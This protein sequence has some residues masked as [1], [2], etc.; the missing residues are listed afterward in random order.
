M[1]STPNAPGGLF[2]SIELEPEDTCLYRRIFLHWTYGAG[3]IYTTEDIERAKRSHSFSREYD[4]HYGGQ[5]GN[6]FHTRDIDL[7]IEKGN[8]YP[9]PTIDNNTIHSQTNKSMGID[10]SFGSSQFAIVILEQIDGVIN[11][12]FSE[13]YKHPDY[14]SRLYTVN[15]L[16]NKFAPNKIY[17][18]GTS[19]SFIKSLKIS[20]H[21]DEY[22]DE[23]ISECR[24]KKWDGGSVMNVVPVNFGIEHKIMLGNVKLFL[25]K[26]YLAIHH[27]HDKLITALKTA[28]EKMEGTLDKEATSFDDT[29]DA[30]RLAMKFFYFKPKDED[31]SRAALVKSF[32]MDRR[33][34]L[35]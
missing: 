8:N 34:S 18:D 3:K 31:A 2:E 29:F 10:P 17:I 25:E 9:D 1:V 4:L 24:S 28:T 30:F 32:E 26:G 14:N 13:E 35:L 22:Y 21:E 11:V 20:L 16:S 27:K 7:A 23:I 12:L 15:Q 33:F 19:V 5:L 6:I